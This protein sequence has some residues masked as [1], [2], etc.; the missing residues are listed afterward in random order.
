MLEILYHDD[1]LVAINKPSGLLVHRSL[2]DWH[3]TRFAIQLTRDQIGQKV[4]PVHRL[5]KPT[6]GVLLFAL[7][8]DTARL[9]TEQFSAGLVEKTYLA[10]VRGHTEESGIIDHP[11]K[12]ELDKIAD[13]NANQDKPAQAAITHYQRLLAFELPYA[14]DRYPSSRYS[15]LELQPKTGRKHQLRRHMKHISHHMLGDTTHGNGKHNQFFRQ[16]FACQRLLLHAARLQL[17]HPHTGEP[18]IINAPLPADFAQMVRL[19][20]SFQC[21]DINTTP[22]RGSHG[23][24]F[25]AQLAPDAGSPG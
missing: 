21:P 22:P 19:L 25:I 16:Q 12:E 7:D 23:K 24:E 20:L 13:A 6:S 11:L 3:E 9:L 17:T 4:F 5:D 14:V 15:L 10:I 2:I 18:L 8:S 1:H